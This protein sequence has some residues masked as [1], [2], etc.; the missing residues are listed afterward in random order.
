M[1]FS[2]RYALENSGEWVGE[3]EGGDEL[4]CIAS[5]ECRVRFDRTIQT[6]IY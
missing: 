1:G 5:A 6:F 3:E 4:H 2:I